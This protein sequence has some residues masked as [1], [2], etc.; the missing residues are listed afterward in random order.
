MPKRTCSVEECDKPVRVQGLCATHAYRMRRHGTTD[1][2]GKWFRG[3]PEERFVR[4]V[5]VDEVSGCHV[6]TGALSDG[7][8]CF[9]LGD[10]QKSYRAHRFSYE[11]VHGPIP[12][13]LVLDHL[14]RN[15]ACVRVEHLE[16]VTSRENTLRGENFS[17]VNARKTRCP[18]DHPYDEENTYL[19]PDGGRQCKR[20]R[21]EAVREQRESED[22]KE[23][24]RQYYTPSTGVRGQGAYQKE[25]TS[26]PQDH[27]YTE[28]NTIIEKRKK[29][30]GSI[31]EVRKCRACVNALKAARRAR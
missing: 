24:R 28:A 30:D 27:E 2:T 5:E 17:A 31:R 29:P 15:R 26:C 10:G 16:A 14:C 19:T 21:F 13:G 18:Q 25:R 7:Y 12:E 3:T 8:G 6:W 11:L 9:N 20:C 22:F 1:G 4:M 23:K